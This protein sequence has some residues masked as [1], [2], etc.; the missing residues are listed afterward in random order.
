MTLFGSS[1]F[2]DG[3]GLRWFIRADLTHTLTGD[4]KKKKVWL[5]NKL[6]GSG[7]GRGRERGEMEEALCDGGGWDYSSVSTGPIPE[8][9]KTARG[10]ARA[11]PV[12]VPRAK[13][14]DV[15]LWISASRTG[16]E[17]DSFP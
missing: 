9:P 5:E 1:V 4:L 13:S 11:L 8:P 2:A 15:L 14:G 7:A 10:M 6:T 17:T 3:A 12:E 16:K